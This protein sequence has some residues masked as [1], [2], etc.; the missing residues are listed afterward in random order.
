MIDYVFE[1]GHRILNASHR[2]TSAGMITIK[3]I[4]D[5]QTNKTGPRAQTTY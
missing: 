5:E 4:I 2:D 1:E 3:G